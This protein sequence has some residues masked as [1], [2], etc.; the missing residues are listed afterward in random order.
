MPDRGTSPYSTEIARSAIDYDLNPTAQM[1]QYKRE[2]EGALAPLALPY[3][4]SELPQMF[5]DMVD[6][7]FSAAKIIENILKSQNFEGDSKKLEKLKINIEKIV[8][9]LLKNVDS[10]LYTYTIGAKN[11]LPLDKD[12]N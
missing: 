11:R 8:I 6:S 9:Y 5:A 7:G 3:E 10:T 4:M 12:K 1:L 2:E